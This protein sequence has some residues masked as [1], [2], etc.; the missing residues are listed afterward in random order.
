MY[1]AGLG[2]A[3]AWLD[4]VGGWDPVESLEERVRAD[5]STGEE[6]W[7]RLLVLS[8]AAALEHTELGIQA[9]NAAVGLLPSRADAEVH[10]T[11]AVLGTLSR[12]SW[13]S[14]TLLRAAKAYG[15]RAMQPL[16]MADTLR[17]LSYAAMNFGRP[18]FA[19]FMADLALK[20]LE[21]HAQLAHSVGCGH[22]ARSYVQWATGD[23][24]GAVVGYTR[25]LGMLDPEIGFPVCFM[26]AQS[27]A[28]AIGGLQGA[29][30]QSLAR[31]GEHLERLRRC[32]PF[33]RDS[34]PALFLDW[35]TARWLARRGDYDGA[36]E[37]LDF[38][39]A[40]FRGCRSE[41]WLS[42]T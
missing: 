25:A 17:R 23:V 19:W 18:A 8:E 35:A 28:E 12:D 20:Q 6:Q 10:Y 21:L 27:L 2:E 13:A 31:V 3:Q 22:L 37:L 42:A 24:E 41:D 15:E 16:W 36:V 26:G 33:D 5:P 32:C 14:W 4:T 39:R 7:W 29:E 11:M 1:I 9:A 38:A 40:G 34:S 30:M